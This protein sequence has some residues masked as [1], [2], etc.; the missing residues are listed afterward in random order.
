[1]ISNL[2]PDL[3]LTLRISRHVHDFNS[4]IFKVAHQNSHQFLFESL[5]PLNH[6]YPCQPFW[7]FE[8]RELPV[9]VLCTIQ[10]ALAW[11]LK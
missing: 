4:L 10:L 11:L 8:S 7:M 3:K 2:V 1:M 9:C 5:Q 6:C